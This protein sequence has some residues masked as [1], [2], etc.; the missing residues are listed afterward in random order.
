[1]VG[2]LVAGYS[3]AGAMGATLVSSV[4]AVGVLAAILWPLLTAPSTA[5]R[6]PRRARTRELVPVVAGLLAITALSTTDLVMAK[7][8]FD[9][10]LAGAYG[11]ASLI[12]RAILYL[13]AAIVTVV[14]P[15]VA[16]RSAEDKGTHH[17]L[18]GS[19][20]VTG[21]FCGIAAIVYALVPGVIIHVA[22][23]SD[24]EEAIPLL[25]LFGVAMSAYALLNVLLVYHLGKGEWRM[26]WFLVV[27]AICETLGF[28]VVPRVGARV[29]GVSVV[30]AI[31]LLVVHEVA[32]DPSL[33]R[34]VRFG[35]ATVREM[36]KR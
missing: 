34:A 11:A 6:T 15:K 33:T 9:D 23:G 1:M 27:G 5:T 31:T 14:L 19:L 32:F 8:F 17:I 7:F 22:F 12:G 3:V 29:L 26:S 4:L 25:P 18:S 10:D 16:A 2:L 35:A 20:V 28:V 24:Y 36:R 30:T 21:A 13:P